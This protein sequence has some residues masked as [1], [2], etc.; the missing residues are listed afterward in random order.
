MCRLIFLV[1]VLL[2]AFLPAF[3]G[4]NIGDDGYVYWLN[5]GQRGYNSSGGNIDVRFGIDVRW[6]AVGPV[7]PGQ[8]VYCVP[9]DFGYDPA[10]NSVKYCY[11]RASI[12][13][14]PSGSV[15]TNAAPPPADPFL[16]VPAPAVPSGSG[17]GL[18]IGGVCYR[19]QADLLTAAAENRISGADVV[20]VSDIQ[21]LASE[22]RYVATVMGATGSF[23]KGV[24]APRI[25]CEPRDFA[26]YAPLVTAWMF[27][28]VSV[29]C[30][31][32]VYTQ[33]F[34]KESYS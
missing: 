21:L 14:V 23:R 26:H 19:T 1:V 29:L 31:R 33:V 3:A 16:N 15:P 10:V 34:R 11:F 4:N 9:S 27:A 8:S 18:S 6:T 13:G 22:L 2:F 5:G 17:P 24:R 12:A 30:V 7:A 28:L 32:L 25:L 20:A